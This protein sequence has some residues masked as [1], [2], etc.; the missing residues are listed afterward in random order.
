MRIAREVQARGIR[1]ILLTA[2]TAWI[3]VIRRAHLPVLEKPPLPP[4]L[5]EFVDQALLA[6]GPPSAAEHSLVDRSLAFARDAKRSIIH[7]VLL[8]GGGLFDRHVREYRH[9]GL[10]FEIPRELSTPEFRA[11][12]LLHRYEVP[13]QVLTRKY[14]APDATVLELGGCLG[15]ISC[16]MNRRLSDPRRHVVF[17]PHPLI[18]PYLE[19]NR[20]RNCCE[21]EVRQQIISRAPTATFYR[22]DPS[23]GGSSTVRVG[24]LALEVPTTTVERVEHET[25]FTFDSLVIDIEGGEHK[26]FTENVALVERLRVVVA[27]FHPLIIG[28]AVCAEIR[29]RL[30]TAGL[31]PRDRRG[32]VEAWLRRG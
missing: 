32:R 1:A 29:D 13:E 20:R 16:L 4:Q 8:V 21:F 5:R 25:G 14:I 31:S 22:R 30:R 19:A 6:R 15:V 24:R 2:D 17:E 28:N 10:H 26:F 18:I 27:E 11:R 12:F 9:K 7:R 3:P 23:I